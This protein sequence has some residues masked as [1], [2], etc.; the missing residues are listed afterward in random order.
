MLAGQN[1]DPQGLRGA[2]GQQGGPPETNVE[3][4]GSFSRMLLLCGI[5]RINLQTDGAF[6]SLLNEGLRRCAGVEGVD[7]A[8]DGRFR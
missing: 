7:V 3:A 5:W 4:I 2:M 1:L 8:L 6:S